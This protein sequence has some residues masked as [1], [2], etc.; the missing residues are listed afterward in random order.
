[1][2]PQIMS[3]EL[4]TLVKGMD[5]QSARFKM[6]T[7]LDDIMMPLSDWPAEF[8][9]LMLGKHVS[10]TQRRRLICFLAVNGCPPGFIADWAT[11]SPGYLRDRNAVEDVAN[12]LVKWKNNRMVT[13]EGVPIKAWSMEKQMFVPVEAPSFAN[14]TVDKR[15][16]VGIMRAGD[17]YWTD[18]IKR[19]RAFASELQRR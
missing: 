7:T 19:L 1:M 17:K 2:P 12:L 3:A 4:A 16:P 5:R 14:E 10:F 6:I 15:T 13:A 18:A 11:A 9:R 8:A